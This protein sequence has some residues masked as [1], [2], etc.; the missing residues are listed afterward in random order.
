MKWESG[1]IWPC[2][3]QTYLN[4]KIPST[5]CD[6]N[7]LCSQEKSIKIGSLHTVCAL[8]RQWHGACLQSHLH[9]RAFGL[10]TVCEWFAIHLALVFTRFYDIWCKP[11]TALSYL[12]STFQHSFCTCWH[13]PGET[14]T[15]VI[16][17]NVVLYTEPLYTPASTWR[18][19][20]NYFSFY[21]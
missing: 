10:R 12:M 21:A 2:G 8:L 16:G 19:F 4:C 20:P 5:R 11:G 18:C 9:Y 6:K 7:S 13:C 15:I 17:C 3:L 14:Y 1:G